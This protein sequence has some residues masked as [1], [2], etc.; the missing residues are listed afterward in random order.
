[1]PSFL[2]CHAASRYQGHWDGLEIGYLD[3][4]SNK[5]HAVV[6]SGKGVT[7]RGCWLFGVERGAKKGSL[8][9]SCI[10]FCSLRTQGLMHA[11]GL[12]A[13]EF[14]EEL[15]HLSIVGHLSLLCQTT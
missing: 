11:K 8:A 2:L 6:L 10:S 3:N 15:V 13:M 12:A 7:R 5:L 9:Q 14:Q 4:R 1:M